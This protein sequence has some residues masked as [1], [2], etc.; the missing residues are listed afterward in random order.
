MLKLLC[1]L[2][3]HKIVP[4]HERIGNEIHTTYICKRCGYN[5]GATIELLQ[6]TNIGDIENESVY[7]SWKGAGGGGGAGNIDWPTF[8][9]FPSNGDSRK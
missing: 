5:H 1:R 8:K 2:F 4:R 7:V 3:D 6:I 9:E